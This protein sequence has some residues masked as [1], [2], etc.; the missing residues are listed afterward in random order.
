MATGRL[1]NHI[2]LE[3]TLTLSI[4][5][6]FR[7]ALPTVQLYCVA[8]GCNAWLHSEMVSHTSHDRTR[9][10]ETRDLSLLGKSA[11]HRRSDQGVAP[12]L[13]ACHCQSVHQRQ[14]TQWLRWGRVTHDLKACMASHIRTLAV[15][16]LR[17]VLTVPG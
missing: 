7:T 5:L 13:G 9:K 12:R 4:R 17:Y 10:S 6:S 14:S 8:V 15:T 2:P 1:H 16:L 3:L 11:M